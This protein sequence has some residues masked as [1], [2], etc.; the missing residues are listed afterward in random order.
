MNADDL[1]E[2]FTIETITPL[3]AIVYL[4][5]NTKNRKIRP[6]RVSQYAR[7]MA[8]DE[9]Y[10]TGSPI[11][12]NGNDIVDGQHRLWACVEADV[13]FTTVVFR[14]LAA[15]AHRAIDVGMT[16][17]MG[18]ELSWRNESN[19]PLLGAA[20]GVIW[21][22]EHG[23]FLDPRKIPSRSELLE[24]LKQHPRLRDSLSI[25]TATNK[26]VKIPASVCA[27]LHHLAALKTDEEEATSFFYLVRIEGAAEPHSAP[28]ALRRY[29]LN[30]HMATH[31][32]LKQAEWMALSIKAFNAWMSNAPMRQ[33]R[34]RRGGSQAEAFPEIVP[35][36]YIGEDDDA[37]D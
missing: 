33:L 22:Y 26:A 7:D 3:K 19:A 8:K 32:R 25:G 18:D 1:P 15:E 35:S 14:G 31:I 9:W 5:T 12:F 30:V 4:D 10:M 28:L 6:A 34:W 27:G 23:V 24:T 13:P 16:R 2:G 11:V 20:L 37:D 17:T 36:A 29:A 21:R